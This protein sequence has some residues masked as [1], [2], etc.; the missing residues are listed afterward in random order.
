MFGLENKGWEVPFFNQKC[1]VVN[2]THNISL[3]KCL[4]QPKPTSV[5]NKVNLLL[6]FSKLIVYF[7]MY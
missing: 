3:D 5:K 7:M 4:V 2:L 6:E 1:F